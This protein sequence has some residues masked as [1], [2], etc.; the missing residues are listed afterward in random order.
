MP[1][2]SCMSCIAR[3]TEHPLMG[4]GH[5]HMSSFC[6]GGVEC[7]ASLHGSKDERHDG[8]SKLLTPC[9]AWTSWCLWGC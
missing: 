2:V 3:N 1:A 5:L 4:D 6:T 7:R 9:C 8:R